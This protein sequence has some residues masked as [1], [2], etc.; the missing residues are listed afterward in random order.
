MS[1]L[2]FDSLP[3][4]WNA[5]ISRIFSREDIDK[6]LYANVGLNALKVKSGFHAALG[7]AA[8]PDARLGN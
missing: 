5:E 4:F 1:R 7:W 2:R 6:A 3:G 8:A